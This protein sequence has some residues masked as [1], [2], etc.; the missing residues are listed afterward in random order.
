MEIQIYT[1]IC[2][3]SIHAKIYQH[4]CVYRMEIEIYVFILIWPDRS[5]KKTEAKKTSIFT[6]DN[7]HSQIPLLT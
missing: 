3:Y 6:I 2:I 7:T 4:I 5:Q 1:R